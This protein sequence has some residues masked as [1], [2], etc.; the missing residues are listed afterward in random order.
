MQNWTYDQ[1]TKHVNVLQQLKQPVP[2]SLSLLLA[3]VTKK[4]EK[5]HAK[6]IANRMSASTSRARKKAL[7]R[8]MTELN[9]RLKR[10]AL[11]LALLP[12]LVIVVDVNGVITFC[13]EQV[14]RILM[15]T[16][17]SIQGCKLTDI[18]VPSSR[19]KFLNLIKTLLGPSGSRQEAEAST[20]SQ[21]KR[22][23]MEKQAVSDESSGDKLQMNGSGSALGASIPTGA[24]SEPSFPMSVVQVAAAPETKGASDENDNSDT[25]ASRDSKQ[26]SSLTNSAC[27]TRS[28]TAESF[29][30]GNGSGASGSEDGQKQRLKD[31]QS[32]EKKL[33]KLPSSDTSNTSSIS[34]EAKKLQKANANLDRNVRWHNK[35]MKTKHMMDDGA[36]TDDVIGDI[37][38]A[39]NATARLSSLRVSQH[40]EPSSEEDSGY[41]ESNDSREETS[42]SSASDNESSGRHKPLAPTCN[43]C[44]VKADRTTVWCE[45]TSSVRTTDHPDENVE[46]D[47]ASMKLKSPPT[48]SEGNESVKAPSVE[49]H[50]SVRV[51]EI[52]LCLRPIRDGEEKMDERYALPID[53]KREVSEDSNTG[54]SIGEGDSAPSSECDLKQGRPRKRKPALKCNSPSKRKCTENA[55]KESAGVLDSDVAQS[56][57]MMSSKKE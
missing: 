54:Q 52:L 33:S 20:K 51:K 47:I 19:S 43:V 10:Q 44:L 46:D 28:P 35:N 2:E 48:E 56:L 21:T 29:V 57:V 27:L 12:D 6:R 37:V 4:E 26:P 40:S 1:L 25:S 42:S 3:D 22:S 32:K 49:M 15:Y 31:Q 45:V 39:N 7:V 13:S 23:R 30:N 18:L 11:I 17:D 24:I 53:T 50:S 38:T 41:R 5:K 34:A 14:E 16:P 9:A 55:S 36:F 8:E